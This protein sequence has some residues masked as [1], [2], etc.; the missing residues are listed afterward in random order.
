MDT[1]TGGFPCVHSTDTSTGVEVTIRPLR[2]IV[3]SREIAGTDPTVNKKKVYRRSCLR[4]HLRS[5][6]HERNVFAAVLQMSAD[7]SR[8]AT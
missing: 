5:A 7:H 3:K 6:L 4:C 1:V 2:V 8:S